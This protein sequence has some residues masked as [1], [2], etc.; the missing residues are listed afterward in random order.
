MMRAVDPGLLTEEVRLQ[1]V[2]QTDDG[3]GG[4]TSS[5]SNV[6]EITFAQITPRT[7]REREEGDQLTAETQY[8]VILPNRRDIGAADRLVWVTNSNLILE[9][10][11]M[12][13]EGAMPLYRML[14]C[15]ATEGEAAA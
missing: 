6:G 7:A 10:R 5:W 8:E 14:V 11:Q 15:E 1:S 13:D 3:Y 9:I 12:N 2:T 4:M